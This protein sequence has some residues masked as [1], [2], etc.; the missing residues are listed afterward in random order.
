MPVMNDKRRVPLRY[1]PIALLQETSISVVLPCIPIHLPVRQVYFVLVFEFSQ[2]FANCLFR[3]FP[4]RAGIY[5]NQVKLLHNYGVAPNPSPFKME[6]TI[7][8]SEKFIW[9][10]VAF[11]I[12]PFMV[13]IRVAAKRS[14]RLS[15]ATFI[16]YLMSSK[17]KHG[18][19]I[20]S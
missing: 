16:M 6:A 8:L 1:Q 7:S 20:T 9:Q 15:L 13:F 3:L 5:Q 17:I 12:K 4:D 14:N 2:S 11:N 19:T 18:Q 10:P